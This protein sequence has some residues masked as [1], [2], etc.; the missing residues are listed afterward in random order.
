M[1]KFSI[2]YIRDN[3]L[4]NITKE[5]L[6]KLTHLYIAFGKINNGEIY[7]KL[8]NL[9]EIKRIKEIAP[10]IKVLLSIG[11]WGNGGFSIASETEEG[12]IK[13]ASSGIKLLKEH[14]LDGLDLDWEYPCYGISGIDSSPDDKVNF[15]LLLNE[16]RKQLDEVGAKDNKHYLLTI[17]TGADKYYLEGVEI[18]EIEKVLDYIL[19]MTYDLRCGF[20][21][22]TGHHTNLYSVPG[23]LLRQSGD[24]SVKL[25]T[26]AGV[27][28][29]KLVLGAAFYSRM[30]RGLNNLENP[31]F[32]MAP[33][34][35][36]EGP[37]FQELNDNYINKNGYTRYWDDIAKAPY[38]YNGDEL[39]SYDDPESITHKMNYIYENN[40]A[41]IMFWVY[42][43]D[44]K[45][46]LIDAI[47]KADL[48][49]SK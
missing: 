37:T 31:L 26:E 44:T 20:Q 36:M 42:D 18:K 49:N 5:Q 27:P 4:K 41:G 30:W 39:I 25:F 8:T 9:G 32:K 38:L 1:N 12:R 15:T 16:F 21:S 28:A 2:A 46:T 10:H 13:L 34:I 40:L 17:A 47:Y 29:E 22:V 35:T 23:D 11:G 3:G 6:D 45:G 7:T 19:L 14:N 33:C 43:S 48:E 24:N